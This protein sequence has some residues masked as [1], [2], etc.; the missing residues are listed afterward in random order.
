MV[1]RNSLDHKHINLEPSVEVA[2]CWFRYMRLIVGSG[3]AV[4]SA[5][6]VSADLLCKIR[7]ALSN[8]KPQCF[9]NFIE[10]SCSFIQSCLRQRN[11][12]SEDLTTIE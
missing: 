10:E 8:P 7:S 2:C 9:I 12:K 1:E 11:V 3:S 4:S 5:A 6:T